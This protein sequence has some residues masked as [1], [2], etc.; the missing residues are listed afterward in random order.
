MFYF[1]LGDASLH[2]SSP[3]LDFEQFLL[4]LLYS[5]L[6]TCLAL[7]DSPSVKKVVNLSFKGDNDLAGDFPYS[8]SVFDLSPADHGGGGDASP[9]PAA[10]APAPVATGSA[11]LLSHA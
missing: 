7:A 10:N 3:S 9:T 8:T 1:F 4:G 6:V 11:A 2:D 5:L